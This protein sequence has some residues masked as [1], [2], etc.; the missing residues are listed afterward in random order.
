[1]GAPVKTGTPK[2]KGS[3]NLSRA[4]QLQI[5]RSVEA[6]ESQQSVA[7]TYGIHKCTV[8]R[9]L[10]RNGY[11]E[12]QRQKAE[13]GVESV[14]APVGAAPPVNGLPTT[15]FEAPLTGDALVDAKTQ[16]A[17]EMLT[18]ARALLA[19]VPVGSLPAE[20]VPSAIKALVDAAKSLL[21]SARPQAQA[22]A[23]V[24]VIAVVA[25]QALLAEL[26]GT[27]SRPA[28]EKEV[29]TVDVAA[30]EPEPESP[31]EVEAAPDA[32]R[33]GVYAEDLICPEP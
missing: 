13:A 26:A 6:G 8:H 23:S 15:T 14:S 24:Q 25:R 33:Q 4:M 29:I 16:A 9:V 28:I 30:R 19:D 31:H 1:M 7:T 20:K 18:R 5:V 32:E 2:L 12:R 3:P 27:A 10:K 11:Y 17:L 21:D 22:G